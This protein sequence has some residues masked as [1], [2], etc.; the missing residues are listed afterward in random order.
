MLSQLLCVS[1]YHPIHFGLMR[2]DEGTRPSSHPTYNII[3]AVGYC[4]RDLIILSLLYQNELAMAS[5]NTS[6]QRG[7]ESR[8]SI[9]LSD[10]I[11]P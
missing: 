7:G 2:G 5:Q 3:Q 9:A 8:W 6:F 1:N 10:P 4:P 11:S